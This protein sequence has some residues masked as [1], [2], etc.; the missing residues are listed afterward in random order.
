MHR[1]AAA[2][3]MDI[4]VKTPMEVIE[5]DG[6][7]WI[8]MSLAALQSERD[9]RDSLQAEVGRACE[10]LFSAYRARYLTPSTDRMR[11][12]APLLREMGELKLAVQALTAGEK[13]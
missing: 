8:E 7:V 3:G 1:D 2:K 5:H 9:S 12:N 13:S 6:S 4:Q 10:A 11:S